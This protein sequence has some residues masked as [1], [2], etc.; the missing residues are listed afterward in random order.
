MSD[1]CFSIV[2]ILHRDCRSIDRSLFANRR[3]DHEPQQWWLCSALWWPG[4]ELA[5][6]ISWVFDLEARRVGAAHDLMLGSPFISRPHMDNNQ[7]RD[8]RLLLCHCYVQFSSPTIIINGG[9]GRELT[10]RVSTAAKFK[11]IE[12]ETEAPEEEQSNCRKEWNINRFLF[13]W[14]SL[15]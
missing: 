7:Q 9:G 2:I 6:T 14:I 12:G 8:L 5:T 11:I 1:I 3:R 4:G 13:T 15:L 10:R